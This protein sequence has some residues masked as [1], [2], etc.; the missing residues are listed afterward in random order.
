MANIGEEMKELYKLLLIG[1]AFLAAYYV[2]WSHPLVRQ[3]GL[4]AFM[5]QVELKASSLSSA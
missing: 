5:I 3:S 1:V 4:E 2:P